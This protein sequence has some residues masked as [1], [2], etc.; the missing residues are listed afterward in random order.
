M[1]LCYR[2]RLRRC[3]SFPRVRGDVPRPHLGHRRV[4]EFSPRTRGCSH[5]TTKRYPH[6]HVFPAHAGMFL[7]AVTVDHGVLAF[8]PRTRGCSDHRIDHH[9]CLGVF[10][11]HAGMF[12]L[13]KS[14]ARYHVSFPRARGDVP[15]RSKRCRYGLAF[16]PRTRGC[17]AITHSSEQKGD[18]FPAH[19]G[20]F[21]AYWIGSSW[22]M[23]FPRAR[24]D[25]PP[26]WNNNKV[27]YM[28]S[29]RTRGC[30]FDSPTP[31][32]TARVFPAHAGMF[33]TPNKPPAPFCSFPRARGDVPYTPPHAHVNP[34]FS[35]RTRGCSDQG[36][37]RN[38]A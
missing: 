13:E 25:V 11:A 6:R 29:P 21:R 9:D 4:L 27:S 30:S 10:P 3:A 2:K 14:T 18:V 23:C 38:V 19:A 36:Y 37:R 35:P 16:S 31:S 7:S 26:S 1:F 12:R 32:Q 5:T 15:G 34:K 33:R 22:S 8:S 17:S 28:F 24:G 20:M